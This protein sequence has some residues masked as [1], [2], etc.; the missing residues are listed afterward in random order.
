MLDFITD[1]LTDESL[2][3]WKVPTFCILLGSSLLVHGVAAATHR[4]EKALKLPHWFDTVS[5]MIAM[6]VATI[7]G[8]VA[9]SIIWD[10]ILGAI[11]AFV[12]AWSSSLLVSFIK[13]RLKKSDGS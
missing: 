9:G 1:I 6:I 2:G 3:A 13:A 5:E 8:A 4:W 10:P 11:V 7:L 12:G